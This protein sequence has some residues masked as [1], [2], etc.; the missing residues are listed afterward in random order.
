MGLNAYYVPTKIIAGESCVQN[1]GELI[2]RCGKHAIIVTGA[3]SARASGAL[4]D[5]ISVLEANA[6][7]YIVYDKVKSNPSVACC[8]EGAALARSEE[9]DFLIAIG[10]GSPMDAGKAIA[11]L[12]RQDIAEENLFGAIYSADVLPMIFV[13]ITAGTGSEVTQYSVLT[14]DKARTKMSLSSPF[15]FPQ[16]ALLDAGYLK[17]LPR[18]TLTH[19][20]LDAL[21]HSMEGMLSL[22]AGR[23][24]DML[25]RE[26]ICRICACL[27]S[28]ASGSLT[29]AQRE[30][31]LLASTLAGMVIANTGTTAV[32]AMGYSLTY[33]RRIDHGRANALLLPAFLAFVGKS[34][35]DRIGEILACCGMQ[36]LSEFSGVIDGLLGERETLSPEEIE[37]FSSIAVKAGNIRNCIA[38]PDEAAVS[39]LYSRSLSGR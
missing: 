22:R 14:N 9:A 21:S 30:S 7:R 10:G 33:F 20:T 2:R 8:Y 29:D 16:A 28:I 13:P 19:T 38:V 11:L 1:S 39:A 37:L 26:S 31:L 6:Q 15:L 32:H 23:M 17:S 25:A 34:Q 3:H 36:S 24:T 5:V 35:P 12:A 27:E 4:G 18:S